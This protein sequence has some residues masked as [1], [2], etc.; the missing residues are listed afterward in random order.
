[1]QDCWVL[2]FPT[3]AAWCYVGLLVHWAMWG[4]DCW[5]AH[6]KSYGLLVAVLTVVSAKLTL[7]LGYDRD[8]W[9]RVLG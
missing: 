4:R 1:M 2:G 5:V 8:C 7:L 6:D 9:L 3:G